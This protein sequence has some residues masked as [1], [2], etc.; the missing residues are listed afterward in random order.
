MKRNSFFSLFFLCFFFIS[1][2]Q[3]TK[4]KKEIKLQEIN[5][6]EAAKTDFVSALDKYGIPESMERFTNE[7]EKGSV[8]PG[9]RAGIN[10]FY[11]PGEKKVEIL[12][13]IWSEN[14]SMNLAIWYTYKQNKWIPFDHFEYSK[15]A[16]F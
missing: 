5:T 3:E 6:A 9:L 2:V 1:C 15:D 11:P 7:G 16:D 14:D 10:N 13:A 8:F 4:N 12:E